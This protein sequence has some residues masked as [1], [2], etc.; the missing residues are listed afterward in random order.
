MDPGINFAHPSRW[1]LFHYGNLVAANQWFTRSVQLYDRVLDEPE[2]AAEATGLIFYIPAHLDYGFLVGRQ[3]QCVAMLTRAGINWNTAEDIVDDWCKCSPVTRTRGDTTMGLHLFS[4][5][6]AGWLHKIAW[7]LA[8]D[9]IEDHGVTAEE[10]IAALPSIDQCIAMANAGLPH[11]WMHMA[12]NLCN[13][14]WMIAVVYQ[15]FGL[16]EQGIVYAEAAMSPDLCKAGSLCPITICKAHAL[17]GRCLAALG[18]LQE[19]EVAF[20]LA[21][22]SIAGFELFFFDVLCL[23]DMKVHVFDQDGRTDEGT[24]RLKASIHMLLGTTPAREQLKELQVALGLNL[25]DILA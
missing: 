3:Q 20:E 14:F 11:S 23:R 10:V 8:V 19:S 15:K 25:T 1:L 17:K 6:F 5:E 4:S 13:I 7:V 24:K 22:T 9:R 18:K 12:S 21:L 16:H 2:R